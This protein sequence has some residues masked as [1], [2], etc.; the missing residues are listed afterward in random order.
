[1]GRD[2]RGDRQQY[3]SSPLALTPGCHYCGPAGQW[4]PDEGQKQTYSHGVMI[5]LNKVAICLHKLWI[6][7]SRHRGKPGER[8]QMHNGLGVCFKGVDNEGLRDQDA[9]LGFCLRMMQ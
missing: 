5:S 4:L 2:N 6:S 7:R 8:M 9:C 3:S 1:M